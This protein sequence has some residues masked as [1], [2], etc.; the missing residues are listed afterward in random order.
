MN[1]SQNNNGY[2]SDVEFYSTQIGLMRRFE[3]HFGNKMSMSRFLADGGLKSVGRNGDLAFKTTDIE[4][5]LAAKRRAV[6][7]IVLSKGPTERGR[8]ISELAQGHAAVSYRAQPVSKDHAKAA[9]Q[10]DAM[11]ASAGRG[12]RQSMSARRMTMHVSG[13][14]FG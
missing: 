13:G 7:S 5:V 11:V 1:S 8:I 4:A 3:G 6:V 9:Q 10:V 2:P 14:L 12:G